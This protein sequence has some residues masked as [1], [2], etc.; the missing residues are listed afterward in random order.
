MN[1]S[2]KTFGPEQH[3]CLYSDVGQSKFPVEM[4]ATEYSFSGKTLGLL[5][6]HWRS[7]DH[8]K[9]EF[10]DSFFGYVIEGPARI[11]AFFNPK[12]ERDVCS[13][14]LRTGQY[15][16]VNCPFE[17]KGGRVL[18][19]R[20]LGEKT[21]NVFSAGPV[22]IWGRLAYV[23]G[24]SNSL[25]IGPP[26]KGMACL[27]SLYFIPGIHQTPH[28]HPTIRIGV[29]VDGGGY[30]VTPW[31]EHELKKG[32]IFCILPNP[33]EDPDDHTDTFDGV[34]API[35]T[36]SFKTL[37]GQILRVVAFHPDS[38]VGPQD[39]NSPMLNR[40]IVHGKGAHELPEIHTTG[41]EMKSGELITNELITNANA[42]STTPKAH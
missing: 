33:Y 35:G 25:L 8:S 27:N 31:G 9:D 42:S 12:N 39:E 17:I 29:V 11:Y 19:V 28:T 18:I 26:K 38:E 21:L 16:A 4:F 20:R 30:C 10:E 15:F 3:G 40:T 34:T 24:C 6:D 5:G 36:H 14:V 1:P 23:N 37:A 22:E 2:F 13:S 41:E 7:S 32:Q